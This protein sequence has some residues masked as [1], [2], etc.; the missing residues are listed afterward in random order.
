MAVAAILT[1]CS[2][3]SGSNDLEPVDL[4]DPAVVS[5]LCGDNAAEIA[6]LVA[7]AA[8]SPADSGKRNAL[9]EWGIDKPTNDR[10][11][12]ALVVTLTERAEVICAED[13]SEEEVEAGIAEVDAMCGAMDWEYPAEYA[14]LAR[15]YG[16][17]T[18]EYSGEEFPVFVA[19]TS[20]RGALNTD[21]VRP[22]LAEK[23]ADQVT[24]II[25]SEPD[26]GAQAASGLANHPGTVNGKTLLELSPCLL[27]EFKDPASL[28]DWADAAINGTEAEQHTAAQKLLLVALLFERVGSTGVAIESTAFNFHVVWADEGGTLAIDPADPWGI[29][30]FELNPSQYEGEF[31]M[32]E[33]TLKGQ[34]GC[35]LRFG[36]NTMD[37]RFAGFACPTPEVPVTPETP[38]T[39]ENPGCEPNCGN[40]RKTNVVP[41]EPEITPAPGPTETAAPP[42]DVDTTP[43]DVI[44]TNTDKPKEDDGPPNGAI[45]D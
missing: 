42:E 37:G 29:P 31:V 19:G 12:D 28:N 43:V 33:V 15:E 20:L 8:D 35:W 41:G 26:V 16:Y 22:P 10:A 45:T 13:A 1:G 25:L 24:A 6:E 39:P 44:D 11:L 18:Q 34:T 21:S 5:T 2:A 30:E 23:S 32:Y 7:S 27:T 9:K 17:D 40:D 3:V 14:E 38:T 4:S 36:I